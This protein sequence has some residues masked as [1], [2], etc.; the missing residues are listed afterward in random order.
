MRYSPLPP[1]LYVRNRD[2]LA[3]QLPAGSLVVIH[4]NDIYPTNADGTLAHHQNADLFYLTGIDQ[5]ETVLLMSIGPNGRHEDTLLLRETNDTI[6][7]W[8]GE[9]LSREQGAALSGIRDVRWTDTYESLLAELAPKASLLFVERNEHPRQ[10]TPVQTRND[11]YAADLAARYPGLPQKS[12]YDIVGK[13]RQ[14]KAPEELEQLRRACTITAEGFKALLA[15]VHPGMGEWEI[16]A[17]L[18]YE[19]LR[20]GAR[21]FSFLPIVASGA[22]TCVLH[23]IANDAVCRDGDLIL[24]DIGAEYGGYNGDMT[25]TVPANGRFT[26]RQREVYEAVLRIHRFAVGLLRPG[27][28]KAEYERQVRVF[29]G[30]ELVKLGLLTESDLAEKPEDPPAVRRYFMHGTSHFLGIDVHDVGEENPVIA[31]GMVWTVEPG[32]YIKEEAIGIRLENDY[33]IGPDGNENLLA[34]APIEPDDIEALMSGPRSATK[35]E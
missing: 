15:D 31:E 33:Y 6:V 8:E 14:I 24:L 21:K 19:Y 29:T 7:I 2:H 5:E 34:A 17:R 27:I 30:G 26:P 32:L 18:S 16:E 10:A 9:R 23:S 4:A 25:R 1:E 22:R 13:L 12:L 35:D 11:R 3:A 28:R 20:R